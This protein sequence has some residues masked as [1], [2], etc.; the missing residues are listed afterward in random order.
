MRLLQVEPANPNVAHVIQFNLLQ[1]DQVA[2]AVELDL[3]RLMQLKLLMIRQHTATAPVEAAVVEAAEAQVA[4]VDTV[5]QVDQVPLDQ[6]VVEVT[7]AQTNPQVVRLV[8]PALEAQG[9]QADQAHPAIRVLL[10]QGEMAPMAET[11]HL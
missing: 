5:L 7:V 10:L 4:E 9:G 2:E 1:S 6:P 3:L 11:V 8:L